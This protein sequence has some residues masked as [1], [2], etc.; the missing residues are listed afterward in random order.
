ML[1]YS[2]CKL[3]RS[4]SPAEMAERGIDELREHPL[5]N[6]HNNFSLGLSTRGFGDIEEELIRVVSQEID[7]RAME[8]LRNGYNQNIVA[9][10]GTQQAGEI[11]GIQV[12]TTN[13]TE[14][15]HSQNGR[16]YPSS[17]WDRIMHPLSE[18]N[19]INLLQDIT[20]NPFSDEKNLF[21]G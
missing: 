6:H 14:G 8:S 7:R 16:V 19:K 13:M 17:L 21:I 11:D 15:L 1:D 5:L 3:F 18:R 10:T 9:G 4:L 12:Y 20:F 2:L